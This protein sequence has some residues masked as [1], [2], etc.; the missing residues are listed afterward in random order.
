MTSRAIRFF[1]PALVLLLAAS[2]LAYAAPLRAQAAS[3]DGVDGKEADPSSALIA[4]LTYACRWQDSHFSTYL[5][6]NNASAF[7]ALPAEERTLFMRHISLTDNAGHPLLSSDAKNHPILRCEAS[8]G[9]SEF[10]LGDP[11][12]HENLAFI[13]VTVTK[14]QTTQFGLVRE[15]GGWR[16]LSLGLVLFDIPELSQ[17]WA[18]ADLAAKETEVMNSLRELA[19]TIR[20]YSDAFGRLPES[21]A[22]LGPAPQGQI[23]PEQANLVDASLA[24]GEENGYLYRYRIVPDP[25]G[26]AQKFELAASPAEYGRSGKRS[27]FLDSDGNMHA[28]D[29]HGAVA[30]LDDPVISQEKQE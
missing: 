23:S 24:A 17:Q 10:R 12:I 4:A 27:F 30:T 2:F 21:L 22:E 1:L 8:D 6:F 15:G 13:P 11:R 3:T 26:I 25:G 9:T 20:R 28:A 16:I 14:G 7:R 29:K 18:A 5:T 19:L